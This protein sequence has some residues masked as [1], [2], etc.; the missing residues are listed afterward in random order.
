VEMMLLEFPPVQ[1]LTAKDVTLHKMLA[2]KFCYLL[3][4][5]LTP[6]TKPRT[7]KREQE[8]TDHIYYTLLQQVHILALL[9]LVT[10]SAKLQIVKKMLSQSHFL[11]SQPNMF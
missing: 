6:K 10:A 4:S 9:C 1:Q 2:S 7:A 5:N 11:L 8:S 3:F